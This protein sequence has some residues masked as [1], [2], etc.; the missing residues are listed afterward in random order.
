MEKWDPVRMEIGTTRD[1]ASIAMATEILEGRGSPHGGVFLS[2]KHQPD[3]IIDR[4]AETNAYLH[5]LF[6]GQFALGKFNMDPKKVAWE[7]GPGLH[8][9]NGGIKVSGKGETNV[10]GLFAAGEV[11]GGTMGANRLS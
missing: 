8:Y 4:A 1:V 6:Y 2:F 3:E 5:D 11:Q 9:W 7:I 10:P